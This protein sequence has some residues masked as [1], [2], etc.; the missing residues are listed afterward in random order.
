MYADG[1]TISVEQM[2]RV[3]TRNVIGSREMVLV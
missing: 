2:E 3:I 1:L